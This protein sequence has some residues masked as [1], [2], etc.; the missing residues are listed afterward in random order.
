MQSLTGGP[1]AGLSEAAVR[2]LLTGPGVE[3]SAGLEL[4]DSA[5]RFI[6][7]ISDDLTGG[8]VKWDNRD[9]VHANCR[10]SLT[11]ELAWG[12]D[13]VRP[14]MVLSNATTTARFDLPVFVLTTPDKTLGEDPI[15]Y[16]VTGYDLLSLL[17]T[18]G[19]ADTYEVVAGTTYLQAV[20]DA[21]TAS[22]IGVTVRLDGDRQDAAL[23]AT[24][25]W[26]LVSPAPSWLRIVTDLLAEI[27]YTA[28]WFDEA[29]ALRS[30]PFAPVEQRP[31][32]WLLD[33]GDES[34]DLL[35]EQRTISTEAGDVANAWRFI[36]Q[37]MDATPVEGDGIY[38]PAVNQSDGP[39]STDAVGRTV[40]KVVW[41]DAADQATLVAQGDKIRAEDIAST[42]TVRLSVDPLPIWGFADVVSY[43]DGGQARKMQVASWSLNL[44]GSKGPV[45]L[46]G[47]PAPLDEP[48][49][50]QAKATI[51]NAAVLRVVV[52]GATEDSMANALDA[53][54][55]AVGQ[56]VT[57]TVRN[58]RPPL[59]QGEET[60]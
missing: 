18:T 59:I 35:G 57:V 20:R 54:S 34:T 15:T 31:V 14:Y 48:L 49:E 43:I 45:M 11:R 16:E 28:P 7:D 22:G 42:T 56:R 55:Y 52:D 2:A 32:E 41:L 19:P 8:S 6:E 30:R 13:R 39:A 38:T 12:R 27:A 60:T 23:P 36:R 44:D 4:V 9:A 1:R 33:A 37:G 51:T 24:R 26:A 46:G 40:T 47:A 5:G 29:G 53:A 25:V 58:P 17:Q 50:T 10:L 3:I 21:I